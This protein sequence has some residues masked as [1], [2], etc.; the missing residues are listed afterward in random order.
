M[1]SLSRIYS[2]TRK[3]TAK[4]TSKPSLRPTNHPTP[5][6]TSAQISSP[7]HY[8]PDFAAGYCKSDGL[9]DDKPF[10]FTT[11]EPCCKNAVMD[12]NTCLSLSIENFAPPTTTTT[13]T[14]VAKTQKPSMKPTSIPTSALSSSPGNYYPDFAAGYCKSDRQHENKPYAFTSA[15]KCC[16]NDLMDYNTCLSLSIE[17]F[18]TTTTTTTT[19]TTAKVF[20]PD[21][22]LKVCKSDGNQGESPYVFSSAHACC[23]NNCMN[24]ERCMS[25]AAGYQ[26]VPI[27]V[28]GYCRISIGTE[29]NAYKYAS[30]EDCC[31]TGMMGDFDDCLLLTLE[32]LDGS[33]QVEVT[34]T[35][36]STTTTD[37]E[38]YYP[39]LTLNVCKSD[40]KQGQT[41]FRFPSAEACCDLFSMN[42]DA[43][44]AYANG[45]TSVITSTTTTTAT[46]TA[47]TIP[48]I[49]TS[50]VAKVYYPDLVLRVC[51]SDG[52]QGNIP[53]LFPTAEA[54]CDNN[55]MDY[56]ACIAYAN[57]D[58][59]V[60]SSTTTTSTSTTSAAAKVFYPDMVLKVCK[61]DGKQGQIPYLFSTAHEC[62]DNTYMDYDVCIAYA[63]GDTSVIYSTTSSS[64]ATTTTR[65]NTPSPT[66]RIPTMKPTLKPTEKYTPPPVVQSAIDARKFTDEVTDGFENGLDGVFPWGTTPGTPW[67]IDRTKY[68]EGSASVR[69]S[70]ISKGEQSDLYVAVNSDWGG[71]FFFSMKSDVQ[72]PYSG[73]YIN[74]DDKSK[75]GYTFP[76]TDWRD[77]SVSVSAGQ[78]VLMFRTWVPSIATGPSPTTTGT[79]NIDKVSF[80]PNLI[81]NFESGELT[82]D[83]ANFVG[84]DW[85][86]DTSKQHAGSISLRTPNINSGQKATFSFEFTTSS[87]GSTLEFWHFSELA[88]SDKFQFKIDGY[89]V[90]EL[91]SVSQ[92]WKME[93]RSLVPG[94]HMLEWTY[95]KSSGGTSSAV[96]IDDIRITPIGG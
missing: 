63:N 3:P 33:N 43:C 81:E 18:V 59:S 55:Y 11:A 90:V 39:D 87:K 40:S 78:H 12:Y 75:A 53:Y 61:S 8:Y 62:C 89:P 44:I 31:E 16:K 20:Y 19:T 88:S 21:L 24:Y 93:S 47:T 71:T 94:K 46:T 84:S 27:P 41:Y 30:P 51:K 76:T 22:S 4:P 86:F 45:N 80:Q 14:S 65:G 56:D 7:G 70:P 15:E 42:Y 28:D 52:K 77:L 49:T 79:V 13:T 85:V 2:P 82:W 68:N 91:T 26:Y 9:H 29:S 69:S 35:T 66:T 5:L 54:C 38:F 60:I 37:A 73:F 48:P 36:T 34:T 10:V 83:A 95:I 32:H 74:I 17:N 1:Q 92:N 64:L 23:D 72:M 96:W 57:G 50:T 6:P 25:Y 67:V 58:T